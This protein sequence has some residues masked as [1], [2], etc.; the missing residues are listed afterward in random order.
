MIARSAQV[1]FLVAIVSAAAPVV[2][3]A[4]EVTQVQVQRPLRLGPSDRSADQP[5]PSVRQPAV[6]RGDGVRMMRRAVEDGAARGGVMVA[7]GARQAPARHLAGLPDI[8]RPDWGGRQQPAAPA[9]ATDTRVAERNA[10]ADGSCRASAFDGWEAS[11]FGGEAYARAWP[12]A[13]IV[14][15]ASLAYWDARS[16]WA[17][18]RLRNRFA[19]PLAWPA[20]FETAAR[21]PVMLI[22]QRAGSV[23]A[24]W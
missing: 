2:A 12:T 16:D 15:G 11:R 3:S 5:A 18:R 4:R 9:A 6:L 22:W 8:H 1:S 7:R 13:L 14:S 20:R 17:D 23:E 19:V 24:R 21:R 10:C